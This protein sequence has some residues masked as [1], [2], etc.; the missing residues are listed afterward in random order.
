MKRF[1][2]ACL[3]LLF[4]VLH[5]GI[6][7]ARI[8]LFQ[9]WHPGQDPGVTAPDSYTL[10]GSLQAA[11]RLIEL[12]AR[13]TYG[14][15][16]KLEVGGQW[17]IR[18][19]N[20]YTGI[21]D[22]MLGL[23][24]QLLEGTGQKPWVTGEAAVSLPTADPSHGIGTGAGGFLLQWALE[25]EIRGVTGSLSLGTQLNS[26]NGDH[27]R[28]GN[29]FFYRLGARYPYSPDMR[30]HGELKGFNHAKTRVSGT[31][32]DDSAFQELYLAPGIDYTWNAQTFSA[33]LLI[34]LTPESQ[35]LALSVSTR[36]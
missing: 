25:K 33:S 22:L 11:E 27:I 19:F 1:F 18:H 7:E 13:F 32:I 10:E 24:Y 5:P 12:P 34:G 9:P 6:L 28:P 21:S 29:V 14:A 23:K 30:F 8:N 31:E 36:L 4:P 3:L 2:T 20:G 15:L 35:D 16:P 26:E 17:G